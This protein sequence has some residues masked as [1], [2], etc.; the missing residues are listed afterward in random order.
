MLMRWGVGSQYDL[1]GNFIDSDSHSHT[2]DHLFQL[3]QTSSWNFFNL[4]DFHL[5]CCRVV[6]RS[7]YNSINLLSNNSSRMCNAHL[8]TWTLGYEKFKKTFLQQHYC[9]KWWLCKRPNVTVLTLTPVQAIPCS[10]NL[11]ASSIVDSIHP[12]L[13]F[14]QMDTPMFWAAQ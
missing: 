14:P 3:I 11:L 9:N 5:N 12:S 10:H 6:L 1:R 7:R 13:I 8:R 2:E 4:D